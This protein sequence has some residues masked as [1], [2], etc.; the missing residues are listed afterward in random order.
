MTTRR[1]FLTTVGALAAGTLATPAAGRITGVRDAGIQL[2]T[3]RDEMLRDARGTLAKLAKLGFKEVESASSPKGRYYGLSPQE[4]RKVTHDLGM[5]L[6]SS[7]A[8]I[9]EGQWQRTVD[10]AAAAGQHYLVCPVL[11][12]QEEGQTV[13]SYGRAAAL[14]NTCAAA[15]QRAGLQFAY[16]N[17]AYEFARQGGRVLY[18]VLLEETDPTL[19]KMEMDLGW[20]VAAGQDPLRYFTKYPGRFPLWHLKDMRRDKPESTVLGTGRLPIAALLRQAHKS[21]M[22]YF[23]MEQENY[24]NSPLIDL[25]RGMSYLSKLSY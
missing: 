14:F 20:A 7:H 23:F 3:V 4:I 9:I 24:V 17:H 10:E 2:Y 8:P 18:D 16:H 19:V 12:T 6:R 21:G 15:C 22:K 25:S 13:S 5:T 11:P 1:E